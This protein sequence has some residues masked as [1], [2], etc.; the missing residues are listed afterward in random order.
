M[1]IHHPHPANV[2]P[3]MIITYWAV[4]R[5]DNDP[6][7]HFTG[8]QTDNGNDMV[9]SAIQTFNPAKRA[10]ITRSGHQYLLLGDPKPTEDAPIPTR[11]RWCEFNSVHGFTDVTHEY[12]DAPNNTPPNSRNAAS[13]GD[14]PPAEER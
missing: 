8:I 13:D 4:Y 9:S 14:K 2:Q 1:F 10:G 12:A 3:H 7:D 11:A 5:C 6:T